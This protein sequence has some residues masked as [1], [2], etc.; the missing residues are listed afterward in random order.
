LIIGLPYKI[1]AGIIGVLNIKKYVRLSFTFFRFG[2]HL[3]LTCRQSFTLHWISL[4]A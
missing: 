1:S 4:S 3:A 2:L